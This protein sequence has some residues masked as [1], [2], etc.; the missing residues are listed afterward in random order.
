MSDNRMGG[1]PLKNLRHFQDLCGKNM[2]RKIVL[3]TTMWDDVNQD[4]GETREGELRDDFWKGMVKRGSTIARFEGT[5]DSAFR[6]IRP[7]LDAANDRHQLLLQKEVLDVEL[8]LCET[9]AGQKLRPGL[10]AM[11]RQQLELQE[12]ILQQ[13]GSADKATML[14]SL[15]REYEA[16]KQNPDFVKLLGELEELDIRLGRRFLNMITMTFALKSDA[17]YV[18]TRSILVSAV[19]SRHS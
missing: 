8:S 3:T 11:T 4:T 19:I 5:R 18:S 16:L 13:L 7:L 14:E 2:L 6:V 10:R 9:P 17:R 15:V 12:K 1:T